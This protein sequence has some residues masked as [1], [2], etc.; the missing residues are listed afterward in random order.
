M[1]T[2]LSRENRLF[3][4]AATGQRSP[5]IILVI[6]LTPV[7]VVGAQ[8]VGGI[9]AVLAL[10]AFSTGFANPDTFT[11]PD[12][13]I[14]E[15]FQNPIS[16]AVVLVASFGPIF[17]ILWAWVVWFE[18]RPFFT[19]GFEL[20]GAVIKYVRG[21]VIGLMMFCIAVGISAAF[22]YI[23][24][25]E[26]NPGDATPYGMAALGGVLIVLIG[27]IVQGAGEEVITRGWMM[28][29]IGARYS[30]LLGVII[31]SV[32]FAL[33]HSLNPNLSIIAVVNLALFGLFAALF[34]LYEEG[35]WGVCGIHTAWN[36]VQGNI[37]G[38]EV[39]GNPMQGG[40]L[41]NLMETGPDIITGG[42]F[43]PEGGLAVTV[44]LVVSCVSVWVVKRM[45]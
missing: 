40:S 11:T 17:L 37:L 26:A 38:F 44:V 12:A 7:F 22:G 14:G 10:I 21:L 18:R 45:A 33:L 36:W 41:F 42:P 28:Q 9:P 34:T 6:I 13:V 27:W 39:S 8:L 23:A 2:L 20:D 25:A 30:P 31:S 19:L 5:H 16:I 15:L 35:L 3:T 4:L 32:V 43:G 29:T 1:S 24:V